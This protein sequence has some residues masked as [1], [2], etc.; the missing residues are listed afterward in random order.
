[1]EVENIFLICKAESEMQEPSAV[2][3]LLLLD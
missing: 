3:L 1:L 2:P